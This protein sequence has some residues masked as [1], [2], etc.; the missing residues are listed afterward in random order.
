MPGAHGYTLL[1]GNPNYS[2][3]LD[4][5]YGNGINPD[6]GVIGDNNPNGSELKIPGTT[7]SPVYIDL[8]LWEGDYSSYAQ[9]ALAG[10][11]VGTTG[12]FAQAVV[13]GINPAVPWLSMPDVLL[14][15]VLAGDA[16]GDGR[17]DINDLTVVL[18]HYGQTG[19]AWTQGE[20]TGDGTVDINDLTIVLS[21]YGH[22]LGSSAAWQLPPCRNRAHWPCWPRGSP[23][24]W[25]TPWAGWHVPEPRRRAWLAAGWH[26][27][28]PRRRAWLAAGWHIPEPR[29]RAWLAAG[30]HVPEP[31]RRAWLAA[32]WHVPEP[33]RRAWLAA[34]W[35]VP[36]PRRRAWLAAGWH[37]P[38]PRRRAWLAAGWH[39]PEPRRRAWLAAGWHVP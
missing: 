35:H 11:A 16:N 9:A 39:V 38:E 36:E 1:G 12:V 7:A 25:P 6:A 19:M 26:V 21:N 2:T 17:V 18:A 13:F 4:S 15:P 24:Y 20:F 23:A 22:S 10:A 8:Y 5:N 3:V 14:Q 37:V 32:G 33:R 31:R 28:E 30:W 34:G 29:R 27:P